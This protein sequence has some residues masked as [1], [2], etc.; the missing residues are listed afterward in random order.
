LV[1]EYVYTSVLT[2][3]ADVL[4]LADIIRRGRSYNRAHGITG[5]LAFDGDRFCHYLEGEREAVL[6]LAAK[7]AA[8][9]RHHDFVALHQG[10]A[11]EK[12]SFGRWSLAYAL[13]THGGLLDA[14]AKTRGAEAAKMLILRMAELEV[15]PSSA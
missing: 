9:P 8:D 1:F 2:P 15:Q 4:G 3:T 10:F 5:L 12:R 7:I 11:G 6:T 13:D 14:I